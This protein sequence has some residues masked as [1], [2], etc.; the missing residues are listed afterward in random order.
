[1]LRTD[2]AELVYMPSL[3]TSSRAPLRENLGASKDSNSGT[4][5]EN[6]GVSPTSELPEQTMTWEFP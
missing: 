6:H 3:P 5:K 1:M 4:K 2:Q